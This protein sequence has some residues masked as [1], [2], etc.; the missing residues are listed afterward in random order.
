MRQDNDFLKWLVVVAFA[1][2]A[3]SIYITRLAMH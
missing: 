1:V 2:I 3:Y